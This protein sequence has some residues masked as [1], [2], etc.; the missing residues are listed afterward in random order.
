MKKDKGA[1]NFKNSFKTRAF[2]VGGYSSAITLVAILIVFVINIIMD[3][4][5]TRFTKFDTSDIELYTI[6]EQT[7]EI[8]GSLKDEVT[9]YHVAQS[10]SEDVTITELLNRY[11]DLSN[12]ITVVAKDPVLYPNFLS[13]YSDAAPSNNSIVVESAKR[14]QIIVNDKIYQYVYDYS[15]NRIASA[16]NGEKHL[17]SAIDYVTTDILPVVYALT[18]HGE[19]TLSE[20]L[21][22]SISL[23]NLELKELSLISAK[24]IPDDASC[25]LLAAPTVDI[26][27]A[28]CDGII[29]YL[30][31]GGSMML[32]TSFTD[33]ATPNLDTVME[34]YG[35][36]KVPGLIFEGD[37][38]YSM[39]G[40]PHYLLPRINEHEITAPL[41]DGGFRV[42]LPLAHGIKTID[43]Y[44]SSLEITGLLGTS[45]SA[46]SKV[47]GYNMVT[48]EKEKDDI[49]G[50][51]NVG[52][53]VTEKVRGETTKVVW[54]P[55]SGLVA[56]EGNVLVGGAN[57]DLFLNCLGFMC[58]RE[59][60]I[61][62]R[63]KNLLVNYLS[64][65]AAD[66][67]M[68][69]IIFVIITPLVVLGAGVVVL[70]RRKK[71]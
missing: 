60:S 40:Y 49:D 7:K 56:D 15:G 44:R 43:A 52:V 22:S 33:I 30:E 61:S 47:A 17:T 68:W 23:E 46:Y 29:S 35:V 57:F 37:E 14:S 3:Q 51:F 39:G 31:S 16:F 2:K 25:I 9:I 19:T 62:I 24:A 63:S 70:I 59:S 45:P 42:L 21:L 4:I 8:V 20:S 12:K 1:K 13:K 6:S 34:N 53:L 48:L 28:E 69:T 32:I 58:E 65:S 38:R 36:K 10:G 64:M 66:G 50:P 55:S 27:S 54:I 11:S 41:V 67:R 18:G 26:T 5:P 71:H